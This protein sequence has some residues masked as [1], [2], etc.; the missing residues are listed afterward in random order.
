MCSKL[1]ENTGIMFT[2]I[3]VE[4]GWYIYY[5]TNWQI[6][7]SMYLTFRTILNCTHSAGFKHGL[8][9]TV[10]GHLRMDFYSTGDKLMASTDLNSFNIYASLVLFIVPRFKHLCW[11]LL[12][13]SC[14]SKDRALRPQLVSQQES[15]KVCED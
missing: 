10:P 11:H 6:S 5:F 7:C 3:C 13:S 15:E 8:S 1:D 2:N 12:E 9:G 4:Y 14:F